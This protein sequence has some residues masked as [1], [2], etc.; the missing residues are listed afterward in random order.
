MSLFCVLGW[1]AVGHGGQAGKKTATTIFSE[2]GLQ[3]EGGEERHQSSVVKKVLVIGFRGKTMD[4][5]SGM[6][7][8][9][10]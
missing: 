7:H 4:F 2:H 5:L 9:S 10:P 3:E 6:P 1:G 8:S